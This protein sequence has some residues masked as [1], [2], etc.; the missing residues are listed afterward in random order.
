MKKVLIIAIIVTFIV[1]IGAAVYFLFPNPLNQKKPGDLTSFED[2]QA[3]GALVVDTKP[4]ECHTKIGQVFIEIYNGALLDKTIV[5]TEPKS[6]QLVTSP[7]K[8]DGKAVG[9]W[10]FNNQLMARLEDENGKVII[11]K[12]IKALNTTKTN[13]LVP[14]V[15]AIDFKESDLTIGKG[16]LFIEKTN[17][18][19]VGDQGP[20]IIPVRFNYTPPISAESKK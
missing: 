6:N 7:F 1:I 10:F 14:F 2:C 16:R 5:V 15:V 12:P 8:I 18:T 19:Y 4:R 20:L 13:G 11:T 9:G 3:A 17:T